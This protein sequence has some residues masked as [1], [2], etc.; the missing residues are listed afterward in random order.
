MDKIIYKRPTGSREIVN[1]PPTN[2][3]EDW[4]IYTNDFVGL[5]MDLKKEGFEHDN[6]KHYDESPF[7]SM[8]KGDVNYIITD[9]LNFYEA[10]IKA[11]SIAKELNIKDK[12][13]RC[14]LFMIV[15][16]AFGVEF[17]IKDVFEKDRTDDPL[18]FSVFNDDIPF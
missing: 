2:T 9:K 7:C 13:D 3:D 4:I 12:Q 6:H 16:R 18:D 10:T 1:P 17:D 5:I 11:T 15:R 8:R 14:D